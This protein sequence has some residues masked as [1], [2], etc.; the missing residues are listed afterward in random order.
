MRQILYK[1]IAITSVLLSGLGPQVASGQA[2]K[3]E[4]ISPATENKAVL[5]LANS[6]SSTVTITNSL[7]KADA[8][9]CGSS[10]DT[11]SLMLWQG[12]NSIA[13][14]EART[15]YAVALLSVPNNLP[16][17]AI[18]TT[19]DSFIPEPVLAP[20]DKRADAG[21]VPVMGVKILNELTREWTLKQTDSIADEPVRWVS[22]GNNHLVVMRC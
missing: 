8:V 10:S 11:V 1:I 2:N 20:S 13:I 16:E 18:K 4:P 3:F 6:A 9:L 12:C 5:E 22:P 14:S 19:Q 17:I 7:P 21:I 15:D